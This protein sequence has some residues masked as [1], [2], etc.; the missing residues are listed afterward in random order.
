MPGVSN[1]ALRTKF[2]MPARGIMGV[3]KELI[4]WRLHFL[5]K[6]QNP[7][8]LKGEELIYGKRKPYILKG[9]TRL[10]IDHFQ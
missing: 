2:P 6:T 8:L 7:T 4:Q 9:L 10:P 5:D 3:P 1:W